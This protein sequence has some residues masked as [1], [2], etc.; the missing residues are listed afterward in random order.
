MIDYRLDQP[1]PGFHPIRDQGTGQE[2]IRPRTHPKNGRTDGTE[3]SQK[4]SINIESRQPGVI[5]LLQE[6][7]FK[8]VADVRL[9]INFHEILSSLQRESV[10]SV[11]EQEV[12]VLAAAIASRVAEF[13][14]SEALSQEE[15]AQVQSAVDEFKSQAQALSLAE[16][17]TAAL[18]AGLGLAFQKLVESIRSL[19]LNTAESNPVAEPPSSEGSNT[20]EIFLAE[21]EEVFAESLQAL[22]ES[23]QGVQTLPELSQP[24]GNGAAYDKFLD[25]YREMQ[26]AS[27]P[28]LV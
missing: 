16:T 11:A 5:R 7:H 17:D 9:R 23:L 24:R 25:I 14:E 1:G 19:A 20:S 2:H 4:D 6:G 22:T 15:T 28:A 3:A 12:P 13:L 8:G 21:L 18:R 27:E 10:S 26:G